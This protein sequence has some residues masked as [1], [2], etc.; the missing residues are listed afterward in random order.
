MCVCGCICMRTHIQRRYVCVCVCVCVHDMFQACRTAWDS[1]RCNSCLW[2]QRQSTASHALTYSFFHSSSPR[3]ATSFGSRRTCGTTH[4]RLTTQSITA[5]DLPTL[6]V[7]STRLNHRIDF[8][9]CGCHSE[10]SAVIRQQMS[11]TLCM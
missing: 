8:V 5:C 2:S 4:P 1:D 10:R 7:M 6:Q 3:T 9:F 11:C